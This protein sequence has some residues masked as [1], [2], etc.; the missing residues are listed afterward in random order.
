MLSLT[1]VNSP[2]GNEL[3]KYIHILFFL[4]IIT[5]YMFDP[6]IKNIG[7]YILYDR[8][9][10]LNYFIVL[11]VWATLHIL[12]ANTLFVISLFRD[13]DQK[14]KKE[15]IITTILFVPI[16]LIILGTGYLQTILTI[17]IYDRR[18]DALTLFFSLPMRVHHRFYLGFLRYQIK[19][20]K[21]L[22]RV[23][24]KNSQSRHFHH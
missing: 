7:N 1:T 3:K 22:L 23:H 2:I 18:T 4:A 5:F 21:I 12:I 16:S 10:N 19:N 11:F 6:D 8:V 17:D 13:L 15:N 24:Q 20:R 9:V 14:T